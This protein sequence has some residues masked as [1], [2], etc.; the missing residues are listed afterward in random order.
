MAVPPGVIGDGMVRVSW[1]TS[2]AG[3][4]TAAA[5]TAGV[6]L[7]CYFTSDGFNR[8]MSQDSI[9][10]DRLC[11]TQSGEDP[12]R[13]KETLDLT[14]VWDQQ[15]ITPS[16]NLAYTTLVPGT[17]GFF[18]VRYAKLFTDAYAAAQKVDVIAAT[19]GQ[20]QRVA[21][22]ANEK[23]KTMQKMFLP[24]GGVTYDLALT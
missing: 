3:T 14:Y 22:A 12:G 19:A 4:L 24:A 2:F 9:V 20:R 17:K 8:A 15:N 10:D 6:D 18:V 23:L 1:I 5:A 21:V 11:T 16:E 7:T 13:Y